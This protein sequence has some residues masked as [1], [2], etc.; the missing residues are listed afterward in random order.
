MIDDWFLEHVAK[1]TTLSCVLVV[2]YFLV[3]SIWRITRMANYPWN[4]NE[5][6][7]PVGEGR[8]AVEIHRKAMEMPFTLSLEDTSV[9]NVNQITFILNYVKGGPIPQVTIMWGP[10]LSYLMR[11]INSPWKV[12]T[13][14]LMMSKLDIGEWKNF[15]DFSFQNGVISD[16]NMLNCFM[17]QHMELPSCAKQASP[18]GMPSSYESVKLVI[19]PPIDFGWS[20]LKNQ[21]RYPAAVFVTAQNV[22][23]DNVGHC[24]GIDGIIQ[25]AHVK[26]EEFSKPSSTLAQYIK[27]RNGQCHIL[28]SLYVMDDHRADEGE[29]EE[30]L[31][32]GE[33]QPFNDVLCSVCQVSPVSRVIIPCRHVCLCTQCFQKLEIC[34]ICRGTIMYYFK[35]RHEPNYSTHAMVQEEPEQL[36]WW[37][38]VDRWNDNFSNAAG[39]V[40]H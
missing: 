38:R 14:E 34:P 33:S 28:Q 35:T 31:V 2:I 3:Y 19:S 17:V 11:I 22:L 10:T 1:V 25:V 6:Q 18:T 8:N 32:D 30:G 12:L 20:L 23:Y 29:S 24:H 39:L 13:K 16:V 40:R 37:R 5:W 21:F 27:M 7:W 36:T 9:E 4:W 26:N 15:L